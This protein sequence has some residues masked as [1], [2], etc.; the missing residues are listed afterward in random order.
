MIDDG[1]F[2]PIRKGLYVVFPELTGIPVSLPF[3][4]TCFTA[5]FSYTRSQP[6]LYSIGIDRVGNP[7]QTGF[8]MASPEKALCD[9]LI[10]TRNLNVR[11]QQALHELLFNDLQMP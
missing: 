10:F 5:P 8:F 6:Q 1:L 11:S 3:L 7:D 4:A 2:Q 9:K